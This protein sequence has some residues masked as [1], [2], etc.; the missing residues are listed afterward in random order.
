M[1]TG[2]GKALNTVRRLTASVLRVDL[3]NAA[4]RVSTAYSNDN[5]REDVQIF[6]KESRRY[7]V[8]TAGKVPACSPSPIGSPSPFDPSVSAHGTS[9]V[10]F[11]SLSTNAIQKLVDDL[12]SKPGSETLIESK[13]LLVRVISERATGGHE[14]EFHEHTDH[15]IHILEGATHFDVGGTAEDAHL[16]KPAEWLA[17]G[18][19][20]STSI[21]MSKGDMLIIPRGT[22]HKRTTIASVVLLFAS[23]TGPAPS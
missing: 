10:A 6:M 1:V 22:P 8:Q 19:K 9:T 4:R 12:Q 7:F 2:P 20:G 16:V 15:I 23:L 3:S 21:D 14:F 17:P 18:S 11:V 13:Q 5:S